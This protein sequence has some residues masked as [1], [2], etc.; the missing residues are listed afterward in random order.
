VRRIADHDHGRPGT[1]LLRAAASLAVL[2]AIALV[3]GSA[4][5]AFEVRVVDDQGRPV[6]AVSVRVVRVSDPRDYEDYFTD[7]H[8][9]V[10][11]AIDGVRKQV[12]VLVNGRGKDFDPRAYRCELRGNDDGPTYRTRR[13]C[14]VSPYRH[15]SAAFEVAL[16]PRLGTR[17]ICRLTGRRAANGPYQ[18][19]GHDSA[20][21]IP[22]R[23]RVAGR[24]VDDL[25][26]W[27]GD[28]IDVPGGP[29]LVPNKM[30][31][32]AAGA[33]AA[34]CPPLEY[35]GTH[36]QAPLPVDGSVATEAT[37]WL[38]L[39]LVSSAKP[40][41]RPHGGFGFRPDLGDVLHVGYLSVEDTSPFFEVTHLGIATLTDCAGDCSD[42]LDGH[43]PTLVREPDAVWHAPVEYARAPE[44]A[45]FLFGDTYT[46]LKVVERRTYCARPPHDVDCADDR[47]CRDGSRCIEPGKFCDMGPHVACLDDADC[48]AGRC[49]A[50]GV[51][52][53][54]VDRDEVTRKDAYR[55]WNA[56]SRAFEPYVGREPDAI[57][58][59]PA[60]GNSVS[61]MWSS[62]LGKW[63][64]I[65]NL[66]SAH[67][68]GQ[69]RVVFRTA[70]ELLGPW[71]DS[72][73][74]MENLGG[75]RSYNPRFV[76][77]YTQSA[78]AELVY[79]TATY[80]AYDES[81]PMHGKDFDYNVFLY[82]TDLSALDQT[83]EIEP[84]TSS[85]STNSRAD[86]RAQSNALTSS[87]GEHGA[88]RSSIPSDQAR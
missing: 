43:G 68:V 48:E 29:I 54:R 5:V 12:D 28:T 4:P 14:G 7:F 82:Q 11:P 44:Q 19:F 45:P 75:Q 47:P 20:I 26:W 79:W 73:L 41:P 18:Y 42:R 34:R 37:V 49:V 17:Q 6:E 39:P 81:W 36:E 83:R 67:Y 66:E 30:A 25:L 58:V 15:A 69:S 80:D 51:I 23:R 8:G 38:D 70:P 33:D 31:R 65:S 55:Y 84:S 56:R 50:G 27:F 64:M 21:T 13:L 77:S 46:I 78:R 53:M 1:I 2:L 22:W 10:R 72:T 71:S 87:R 59:D 85:G 57:L 76:P 35:L 60:L 63:I 40:D 3:A 24:V 62:W 61:V 52:A 74:V 9:V 32:T 16:E 86:M 88:A